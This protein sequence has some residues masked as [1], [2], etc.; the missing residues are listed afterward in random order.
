MGQP[1]MAGLGYKNMTTWH[2]ILE[3]HNEEKRRGGKQGRQNMQ[4]G[5]S[6]NALQKN[7]EKIK[8]AENCEQNLIKKML[9]IPDKS[10]KGNALRHA[11]ANIH[12]I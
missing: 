10:E 8:N 2:F 5:T 4:R 7:V 3:G 11:Y 6:K 1:Q 12:I 9:S